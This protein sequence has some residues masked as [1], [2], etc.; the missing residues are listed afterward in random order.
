MLLASP[1]LVTLTS[2]DV[3]GSSKEMLTS[4]ESDVGDEDMTVETVCG[5]RDILISL[6]DV[7][8]GEV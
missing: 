3:S 7:S 2:K 5:C 6:D 1:L 8:V 4:S